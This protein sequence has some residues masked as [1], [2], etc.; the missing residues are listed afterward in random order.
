MFDRKGALDTEGFEGSGADWLELYKPYIN[1]GKTIVA[2]PHKAYG[3]ENNDLMLQ[4]RKRH[5]D[6]VILCG[7][8]A[9]L[10]TESHMR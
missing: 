2:S 3:P 9:N 10:C 7:M 8:S 6:M 1:D 4:M 5:V